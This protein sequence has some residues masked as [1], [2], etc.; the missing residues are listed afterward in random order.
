MYLRVP[1]FQRQSEINLLNKQSLKLKNRSKN[2]QEVLLKHSKM[3]S[4]QEWK[5]MKK[6]INFG[7]ILHENQVEKGMNS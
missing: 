2:G 6:R 5:K 3:D 7:F 1:I 4:H